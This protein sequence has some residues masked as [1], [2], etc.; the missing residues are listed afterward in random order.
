[1]EPKPPGWSA[2]YGAWFREASVA[3]RYDF[4]PPYPAEVFGDPHVA[5][6]ATGR[7][8]CSTPA[9]GRRPGSAAR[10]ARGRGRRRRPV[11]SDAR[12]GP[13]AARRR[14][15]EPHLDREPDRDRAPAPAVRPRRRGRERALVR[16]GGRPPPLR[17][18][19]RSRRR[20]RARLPRLDPCSRARRASPPDLQRYAAKTDFTPPRRG[21]G[22]RTARPVRT[23]SGRRRR[24]PSRGVRPST[25]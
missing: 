12:A 4:R 25:S 11:D 3:E 17:E 6:S 21:R 9:A 24:L 10:P 7:G 20:A 8:R 16:L 14:S 2:E 1:M 18:C 5:R 13:P 22:A 19:A 15:G 23:S